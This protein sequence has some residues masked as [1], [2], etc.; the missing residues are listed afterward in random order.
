MNTSI[1]K[2]LEPRKA[3]M[4]FLVSLSRNWHQAQAYVTKMLCEYCRYYFIMIVIKKICPVLSIKRK[5]RTNEKM[6]VLRH[7]C[8]HFKGEIGCMCSIQQTAYSSSSFITK[9]KWKHKRTMT[10]N[11]TREP[12]FQPWLSIHVPSKRVVNTTFALAS[13]VHIHRHSHCY[14][15]DRNE[16]GVGEHQIFIFIFH[17]YTIWISTI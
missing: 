8:T 15:I 17:I 10:R 7:L 4:W 5:F 16:I 6:Y 11:A 1:Q 9:Y 14:F 13:T 3:Q 2:V 12:Y